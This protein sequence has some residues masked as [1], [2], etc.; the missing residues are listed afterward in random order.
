MSGG[1]EGRELLGVGGDH[2]R[3][4]VAD[5]GRAHQLAPELAAQPGDD[6]VDRGGR[7]AGGLISPDEVEGDLRG[8]GTT[9]S[10][11]EEGKQ[12]SR[13]RSSW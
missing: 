8:N 6:R 11:E 7:Q 9:T 10:G 3:D 4:E 12:I 5:V 2:G 13:S 1:R